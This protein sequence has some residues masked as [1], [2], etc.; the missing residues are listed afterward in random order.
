MDQREGEAHRF[1]TSDGQTST[2]T[3]LT[4]SPYWDYKPITSPDRKKIAFFRVTNE[5]D[6]K[7]G[8]VTLWRSRI[9]VMNP[10][11]TDVRELTDDAYFNGNLHWTRTAATASPGSASLMIPGS[12]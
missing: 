10:D 8:D 2:I 5:M 1:T 6:K 12:L 9:C 7:T 3:Y 4:E 11:G